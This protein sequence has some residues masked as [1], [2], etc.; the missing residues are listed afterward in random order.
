MKLVPITDEKYINYRIDAM[1][2][3]YK[4]DPQFVDNNTLARY[5]LV[6]SEKEYK[7]LVELTEKLDLE[8]IE[9][10]KFLNNNLQYIKP[11]YL[12]KKLTKE[13]KKINI[14]D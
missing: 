11:L 6:L 10:E 9:A 4:W 13:I 3:C 5:V 2:D 14:F 8:T 12:P 7:E 1:F